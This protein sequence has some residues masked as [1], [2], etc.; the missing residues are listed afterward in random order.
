MAAF[1]YKD[2]RAP[3]CANTYREPPVA[4]PKL[5]KFGDGPC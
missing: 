1:G 3:T 2:G 5:G 4:T